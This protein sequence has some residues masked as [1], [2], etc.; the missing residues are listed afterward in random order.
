[1]TLKKRDIN[2]K[3]SSNNERRQLDE[4]N[5]NNEIGGNDGTD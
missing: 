3:R 5:I 2:S 1:M 4:L